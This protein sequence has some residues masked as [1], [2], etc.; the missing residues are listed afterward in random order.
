MSSVE[1]VGDN[2]MVTNAELA[3]KVDD[4]EEE[5]RLMK[6]KLIELESK[7]AE[8]ETKADEVLVKVEGAEGKGKEVSKVD[9]V[10]ELDTVLE[11]EPFLKA[12]KALSGKSLEGLPLFTGKMEAEVVL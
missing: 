6:E 11:Q 4:R 3:K 12:L 5:N 1:S 9:K 2:T 7:L 8:I 10:S